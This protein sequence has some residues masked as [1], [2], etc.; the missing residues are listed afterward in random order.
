[1]LLWSAMTMYCGLAHNFWQLFVGRVGV[2]LGEACLQPAGA[3]LIAD[4]FAPQLRARAFSFINGAAA[5]GIATSMLAG[6][7]LI[8][9]MSSGSLRHMEMLRALPVWR[10]AFLL[11]G[12]PGIAFSCVLLTAREPGR[13]EVMRAAQ[14]A[15]SGFETYFRR[16]RGILGTVLSIYGLIN[17]ATYGLPGWTVAAYVRRFRVGT[18]EASYLVGVILLIGTAA[19]ALLAGVMADRWSRLGRL[20]GKLNVPMSASFS[21]AILVVA[22]WAVPDRGANEVLG[23]LTFLAMMAAGSSA[24]AVIA[25][26]TP[27][28]FRG[29]VYGIFLFTS[30]AVGITLGPLAVAFVTQYVFRSEAALPY[31]IVLVV[32]P[33]M[34]LAGLIAWATR[35]RYSAAVASVAAVAQG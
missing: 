14:S 15:P 25:E 1:M 31:A 7:A 27:N 26:L 28:D 6:S 18:A 33:T 2:G 32:A 19:G 16:Y 13:R 29:R 30:G 8:T 23:S 5:A 34:L 35:G 12:L 22:W 3:S 11:A 9:A 21:M 24:S 4:Y 10:A 20:G 17:L